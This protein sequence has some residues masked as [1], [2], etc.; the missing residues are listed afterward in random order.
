MQ[1]FFKLVIS[2]S[3]RRPQTA[4]N[5]D[6]LLISFC[7]IKTDIADPKLHTGH[8]YKDFFQGAWIFNDC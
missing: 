2:N 6:R 8:E 3:F 1:A 7:L 5:Q 4:S